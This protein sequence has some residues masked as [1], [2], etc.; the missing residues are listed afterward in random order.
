MWEIFKESVQGLFTGWSKLLRARDESFV[1]DF[2]MDKIFN[3]AGIFFCMLIAAIYLLCFFVVVAYICDY[4]EDMPLPGV[5]ICAIVFA[6]MNIPVLVT[7]IPY[8]NK[9][10]DNRKDENIH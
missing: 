10:L 7:L 2:F 4:V 8:I 6:F 1:S 9:K 3:M 5:L